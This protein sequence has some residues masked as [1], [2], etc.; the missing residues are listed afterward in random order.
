MNL[1]RRCGTL[2][3]MVDRVLLLT[4]EMERPVLSRALARDHTHLAVQPVTTADELGYAASAN[5]AGRTRLVAFSTNVMV[6]MDVLDRV[7]THGAINFHPGPPE[8]PGVHTAAFALYEGL[9]TFGVTVHQMTARPDDGAIIRAQRF[10]ISPGTSREAL[11]IET[12]TLLARVFMAMASDLGNFETE[13]PPAPDERWSPSLRT[14]AQY[15]RLRRISIDL[16]DGEAD[17]RRRA[18]AIE[19]I[20]ETRVTETGTQ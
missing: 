12:Y 7:C 10:P 19:A 6:P 8:V 9:D 4:G 16:D 13:L 1:G 11:E 5:H 2:T 17:R 14:F 20:D 3:P 15:E 18:F